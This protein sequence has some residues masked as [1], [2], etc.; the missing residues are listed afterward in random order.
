M[1]RRAWLALFGA[2][3]GVVLLILTW[4]ASFH[5]GVVGRAD[6]SVLQGFADLEGPFVN[7]L[8]AAIADL[9]DPKPFVFL[10]GAVVLVALIRRRGRVA[11]AVAAILLGANVTTQLLKTL[12]TGTH[13]VAYT[14]AGQLSYK[15]AAWP[16]GHATAAMSLALCAVLVAPARFRPMV[17]ALGAA[18]AV[19]V[20]FSFLILAWHY[21]S[22]VLGGFLVATTWTLVGVAAVWLAD[23]RFPRRG[24]R[25]PAV[26]LTARQALG[27]PVAAALGACALVGLVVIA[28]PQA[29]VTYAHAHK[30]FVIGAAA[31]GALG[32]ALATGLMLATTMRRGGDD[33][34]GVTGGDG[35]VSVTTGDELESA[36][37]LSARVSAG[38]VQR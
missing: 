35:T 9:C 34:V 4:I 13:P 30:A 23:A 21:P 36:P 3:T 31:I 17:A 15:S 27:P 32:L 2:A 29:V 12:L 8:A 16:S 10:A 6:A 24:S 7:W 33:P 22:D 1:P 28:R 5:I 38:E 14:L 26:R 19:S 11:V 37:A 20:C 18:F 25:R